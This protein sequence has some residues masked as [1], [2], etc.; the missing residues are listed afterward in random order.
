MLNI[1]TSRGLPIEPRESQCRLIAMQLYPG[2]TI[3][4]AVCYIVED[5]RNERTMSGSAYYSEIG[6]DSLTIP[7][8]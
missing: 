4:I 2:L 3:G 7:L 1:L 6:R 8:T 5:Y